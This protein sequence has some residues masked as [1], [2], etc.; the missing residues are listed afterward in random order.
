MSDC[1]KILIADDEQECIDFV[2]E[3]LAEIDCELLDARDGEEALQIAREQIPQLIILDVQMPKRDGFS[4]FAQLRA[5]K[6]LAKIPVIML[7]AMTERT[8]IKTNAEDMG[9]YLGSQP[10]AYIDK[11]IEPVILKQSVKRLL[12]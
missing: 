7:T 11:P 5:D 9:Q 10:E 3:A 1:P 6:K 8:G 2:Q 12:K 4:V